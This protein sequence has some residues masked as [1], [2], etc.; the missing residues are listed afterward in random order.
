MNVAG[1]GRTKKTNRNKITGK[2]EPEEFLRYVAV[3]FVNFKKCD[4]TLGIN[5]ND[6]RPWL[7]RKRAGSQVCAGWQDGGKD[8][9]QGDSG[10]PLFGLDKSKANGYVQ[11]TAQGS[12]KVYDLTGF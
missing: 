7:N 4:Q 12:F 2:T 3:P 1:W 10:G 6:G 9:C 8:A 5:S 11:Y